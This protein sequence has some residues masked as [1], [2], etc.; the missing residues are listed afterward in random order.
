MKPGDVLLYSGTGMFSRLIRL[1]TWSRYSHCEVFD[2]NGVTFASRDGVGVNF[3]PVRP[4]PPALVL[5]LR[6]GVPFELLAARAW[7]RS[8]QGQGYDWIGLL[9]FTSA[10]LQGR[11]NNKQF[12]S[13]ALARYFR[14]GI[15]G[16]LDGVPRGD[17][18]SL[19]SHGL[20]P[21]RGRDADAISPEAFNTSPLFFEVKA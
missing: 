9:S 19:E 16:A 13:E 5:R 8:V 6:E 17:A 21:W 18:R 2:G 3:Y 1:K 10:K 12:C 11:N 4:D 7:A 20:D 15:S 14:H